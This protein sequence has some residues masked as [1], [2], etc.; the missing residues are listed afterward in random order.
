MEHRGKF[1][2][3]ITFSILFM[4]L[5][6][7]LLL[8]FFAGKKSYT[9]RFEL[10]GGTLLSGSLEQHVIQGQDAD[11][12]TAVK[13]GAFLRG[14]SASY[15]QVTKDMVIEAVWDYETTPG[16]IYSTGG[17]QNFAEI[18][19][20]HK[21]I[22]G[23]VY[24]GSYYGDKKI[25]GIQSGAFSDCKGITKVYLLDGLLHIGDNAFSGC[26]SLSEIEIPKTIIQIGNG[27]FRNCETLENVLL[28][29]GLLEIGNET[30]ENCTAITEIEIPST[31]T[32]IG[33]GAFRG[34]ESMETLILNEGL[35]EIGTGAFENCIGLRE[36]VIPA[37]VERIAA[38]AFAGC[39]GLIITV[40]PPS[41]TDTEEDEDTDT[42]EET[43]PYADWEKGW[44]GSAEVVW[45]DG[46]EPSNDDLLDD[47]NDPSAPEEPTDG[48]SNP[49]STATE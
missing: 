34:C 14:W 46:Y 37:S 36:V 18:A 7:L 22:Q 38:N 8:I 5:S 24:L 40:T 31:V 16:L 12:P 30:F 15:K 27:A 3:I 19:G 44:Q 11:P 39:D 35:L 41:E 10:N 9:V 28:H 26:V 42:E 32:H 43:N 1:K 21:Y 6:V 23:E 4:V 45:P 17:T 48:E 2:I 47:S 13:D 29:D 49:D 33:E 20:A 25:L